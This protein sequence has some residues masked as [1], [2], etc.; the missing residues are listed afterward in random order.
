ML[1]SIYTSFF[2]MFV[3]TD[4]NDVKSEQN[5]DALFAEGCSRYR[6]QSDAFH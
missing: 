5:T 2:L 6:L 3:S 4:L 1:L